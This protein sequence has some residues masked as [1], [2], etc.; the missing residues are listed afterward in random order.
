MRNL[1]TDEN[2]NPHSPV[3]TMTTKIKLQQ[4]IK[5]LKAK[6][7]QFEEQLSSFKT[8]SIEEA[9]VGDTLEDGSIVLK[10][11]NGIALLVSPASTEVEA[12]WSK[13]FLEV[14][15][16]LKKEGFNPS[17]WFVPTLKQLKLAYKT[18]PG[19]F[20]STRYWSSTETNATDA[21]YQNFVNGLISG[22]DKTN[23]LSVRAFRCVTF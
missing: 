14:F 1:P 4:T 11:E 10:E 2:S 22:Y 12:R 15:L 23:S 5:N 7:S 17:Q 18:I 21:C 3:T 19:E 8:V 20:S 16:K 6:L 9:E 13:E